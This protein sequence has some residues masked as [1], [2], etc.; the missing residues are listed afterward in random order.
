MKI[1]VWSALS[2]K[3]SGHLVMNIPAT[4]TVQ[5]V[6]ETYCKHKGVSSSRG[7]V[8]RS[9]DNLLLNPSKSLQQVD[10]KD[11]E[12]LTLG[13]SDDEEQTFAFGSWWMVTIA[14]FLIGTFG[15]VTTIMTFLEHVPSSEKF[16]IVMDAGSS[17]SEI[18][19]FTWNGEKPLD[20]ADVTLVHRCFM[21]G[22]VSNFATHIDDLAD[23]LK[24]CM[25]EAE[26]HVPSIYQSQTP[27]YIGATAGMRILRDFNPEGSELI[28]ANLREVSRTTTPFLIIHENVEILEGSAEGASGWIAV[29][30]LLGHLKEATE[31]T[32]ASLDVGGASLQVTNVVPD[33]GT[34]EHEDFSLFRRNHSVLS[35]SFLC[36]GIGEAQHRYDYFM[37]TENKT[38]EKD[39]TIIDPCLAKGITHNIS[40]E[41]LNGPCTLTDESKPVLTGFSKVKWHKLKKIFKNYKPSDSEKGIVKQAKLSSSTTE[42]SKINESE[43][44]SPVFAEGSSNASMCNEKIKQLFNFSLCEKTFTYGDCMNAKSVPA[45]RGDFVAFSGLFEQM[46]QV[47]GVKP[48]TSLSEFKEIV[49][50]VCSLTAEELYNKYPDLPKVVVEDLCFDALYVYNLLTV[51]LGIDSVEWKKVQFIDE[52]NGTEIEWPLGFMMNQTTRFL[53][54]IPPK[55]LAVPVFCLL[56]LLFGAF[57]ISGV[58][59][60]RHSFKIKRQST[61]Y[62]R[63]GPHQA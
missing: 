16:G 37:V 5:N 48:E 63:C 53:A 55:P 13:L 56:L 36:Y 14:A 12:T 27:F 50:D 8:M 30:Y 44:L 54:D 38:L 9:R 11:G 40:T 7:Y 59:F 10:V 46:M 33:N 23:Y 45:I 47:L 26:D 41:D 15:L 49:F 31:T 1:T 28:L 60:C 2:G 6:L 17:H 62:Q 42:A 24:K 43:L 4:H 21:A 3:I 22:G 19:V 34:W 57:V 35:Q 29:N 20:T 61:S 58:L 18:F 32:A 39:P 52:I 51:G 25:D